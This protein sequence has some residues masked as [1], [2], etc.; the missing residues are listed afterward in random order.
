MTP[1]VD[2]DQYDRFIESLRFRL[3]TGVTA[4]SG[5][6]GKSLAS[7]LTVICATC[8]IELFYPV[9][10]RLDVSQLPESRLD[11]GKWLCGRML[12]PQ[13][14]LVRDLAEHE[15]DVLFGDDHGSDLLTGL[16]KAPQGHESVL[17]L[18]K[19]VCP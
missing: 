19:A 8:P 7:D 11:I 12:A 4:M 3:V 17:N 9:V 1:G 18:L 14:I 15:F 16:M 2:N 10:Y 13:E 6:L 5:S